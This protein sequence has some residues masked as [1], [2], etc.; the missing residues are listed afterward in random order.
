MPSE[1][2]ARWQ[3]RKDARPSE[4]LAAA[5]ACFKERGFATTRLEDVAAKAGVT[6]WPGRGT[7]GAAGHGLGPAHRALP[8]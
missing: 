1:P 2:V 7:A 5:L 6:A 8:Y 3:R 4:I